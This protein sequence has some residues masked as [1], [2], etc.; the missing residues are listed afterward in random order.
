MKRPSNSQAEAL[1]KLFPSAKFNPQA[2]CVA[3]MA[4][5]K[6]K[7]FKPAYKVSVKWSS[8]TIVMLKK[9]QTRIPR[10]DY[11]QHLIEKDR[12][13]KVDLNRLMTPLE[14]KNKILSTFECDDYTI[15]ECAK[16]GYLLKRDNNEELTSHQAIDRR[17]ALYLCEKPF[18]LVCFLPSTSTP[19]LC[20]CEHT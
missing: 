16:G 20:D 5:D 10:G 3:K 6:K 12:V 9:Y 7:K 1:R 15:L 19:D 4:H 2:E 8:V 14:V 17:G 18:K 13:K 11:R